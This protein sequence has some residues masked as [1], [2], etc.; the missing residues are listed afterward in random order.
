MTKKSS[1]DSRSIGETI[2][3]DVFKRSNYG[4]GIVEKLNAWFIQYDILHHDEM[5]KLVRKERDRA[6]LFRRRAHYNAMKHK[7][8]LEGMV[9]NG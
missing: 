2:L 5:N 8:E 3:E 9:K 6:E 4:V 1:I 7:E